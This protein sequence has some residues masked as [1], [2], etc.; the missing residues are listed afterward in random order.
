MLQ[1]KVLLALV[2]AVAV[3]ALWIGQVNSQQQDPPAGQ[4][5]RGTRRQRDPEEARRRMEERRAQAAEQMRENLGANEEEW[6]VLQPRIEKVQTLARQSRVGIRGLMGR[7]GRRG[8]RSAEQ[9]RG[10]GDRRTAR[11]V[12][13]QRE[14]T[15]IEKKTEALRKL[16][17]NKEAKA[18]AITGALGDLRKARDKVGQQLAKARDKLREVVTARQE[19]HLVL[20]GML[21]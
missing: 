3:S 17:E 20:W 4:R 6:K 19:A 9:A 15:D 7:F 14:Q 10:E 13:G 8:R 18:K 12:Q 2:A 11:E 1:R 16:L 21:D 5:Q